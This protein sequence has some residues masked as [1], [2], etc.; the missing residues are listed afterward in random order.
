MLWAVATSVL[1]AQVDMHLL[2]GLVET[3]GS[4]HP[5]DHTICRGVSKV[6]SEYSQITRVGIP[7]FKDAKR[8]T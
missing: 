8:K 5:Y 7:V 6:V 2:L 3:L 1:I 4:Y